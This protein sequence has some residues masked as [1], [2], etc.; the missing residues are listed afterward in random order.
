[1]ISWKFLL[2][3]VEHENYFIISGSGPP[4]SKYFWSHSSDVNNQNLEHMYM[5][6]MQAATP[7][8]LKS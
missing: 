4:L 1:M 8:F 6:K 7:A 3:W 5:D 2:G